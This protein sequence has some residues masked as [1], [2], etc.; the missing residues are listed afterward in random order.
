[1]KH[2]YQRKDSVLHF[3]LKKTY[4]KPEGFKGVIDCAR[5]ALFLKIYMKVNAKLTNQ[6]TEIG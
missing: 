3:I 1:M 5:V 4:F 6:N 2:K